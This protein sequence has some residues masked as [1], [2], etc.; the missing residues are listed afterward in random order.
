MRNLILVAALAWAAPSLCQTPENKNAISARLNFF[1]Y[2]LF[3]DEASKTST[4]SQ[5]FEVSYFRNVLPFLNV[6]VPL[7]F[8]IASLPGSFSG[9]KTVVASL[10][11]I[12]QLQQM[13]ESKRFSPFVFGGAGFMA[14]S[15][16]SVHLNI[17]VGVGLNVRLTRYAFLSPQVE[18]RKALVKNR[19]HINIGLGFVYLLHP[20]P[21]GDTIVVKPLDTDGDGVLDYTDACPD[22]IG[23]AATF[24]CPDKDGD[25]IP[26]K[27]DKCPDLAGKAG[28]LGCPDSDNDGFADNLDDCPDKPGKV[29]GCPDSDNDGFADKDDECPTVSGRWNGCPDSDFDGVADKNDKCPNDQIGRAHV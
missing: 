29:N 10:D 15:F 27:E 8:G 1:D 19:D 2:G 26:D 16:K 5:G 20:S 28:T 9:N 4:F 17:P 6:G 21:A 12:A 13:D 11:A 7:K 23:T 14:E 24:G 3:A 25:G 22:E 18:F